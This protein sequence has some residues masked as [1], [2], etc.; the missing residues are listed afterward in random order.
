[1]RQAGVYRNEI[2]AGLLIEEE[3]GHFT[4]RYDDAYFQNDNMP[5][6]SL[7]LTKKQQTYKRDYLF[8][9]FFNMLSEGANKRL[10]CRHYQI[11]EKDSFGLLL[12]TAQ[13]DTI[14]AVTIK[15]ISA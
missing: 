5:S 9:F 13:Y 11:D 8:S 2:F 14:G 12:A 6:I 4:F 7:T 3:D 15:P 1:M 10:Q